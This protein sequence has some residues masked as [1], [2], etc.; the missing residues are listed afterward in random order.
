MTRLGRRRPG[1]RRARRREHHRERGQALTRDP[2]AVFHRS[3]HHFIA[4][5][6][7]RQPPPRSAGA[8]PLARTRQ[9]S[10]IGYTRGRWRSRRPHLPIS[11]LVSSATHA[12]SRRSSSP[13]CGSGSATTVCG[14]FCLYMTAPPRPAAWVSRREGQR[15]S[16]APTPAMRLLGCGDPRRAPRRPLPRSYRARSSW[17]NHHRARTFHDGRSA[18]CRSST[19]GRADR[20]RHRAL[21]SRT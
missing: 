1:V 10:P 17:R 8:A 9:A 14:L 11:T 12:G 18:R 16:T 2:P 15:P 4:V 7:P 19:P 13:R 3:V 6:A 21:S 5:L 20:P